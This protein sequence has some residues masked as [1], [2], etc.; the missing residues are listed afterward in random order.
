MAK[1]LTI[2]VSDP[3]ARK[4]LS[5]N[6]DGQKWAKANGF[7]HPIVFYPDQECSANS[8]H[9]ILAITSPAEGQTLLAS[10]VSISGKAAASADFDHYLL[11]YGLGPNPSNWQSLSGP[12]ANP[13]SSPQKITDWNVSGIPDG[14]VTLRLTVFSKE[15]GR[16]KHGSTSTYSNPP[17]PRPPRPRPLPPSRPPWCRQIPRPPR[18]HRPPATPRSRPR[19]TLPP[20]SPAT[21]RPRPRRLDPRCA[22]RPERLNLATISRAIIAKQLPQNRI[23]RGKLL[24]NLQSAE[25]SEG[26]GEKRTVALMSVFAAVF[27]TCMKLVVGILTGSLGSSRRL[28]IRAWT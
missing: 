9:P 24:A 14:I 19:V 16:P 26:V 15:G 2:A 10:T 1:E 6:S 13:L 17:P 11:E 21:P 3:W 28:P 25:R 18:T 4:W 22:P 7:P 23:P 20:C 27:L 5:D 8:P 12:S